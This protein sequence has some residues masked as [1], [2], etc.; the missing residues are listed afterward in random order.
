MM[1]KSANTGKWPAAVF[2][3][4][5]T[6]IWELSVK[7]ELVDA[8]TLPAPS[9]VLKALIA[10]LPSLRGHIWIT[11]QEAG[12]GFL[13]AIGFSIALALLMDFVPLIKKGLYPILVLS[14][15]RCLACGSG[16]A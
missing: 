6:A 4:A 5:L 2:L 3:A 13:A 15:H 11:L 1:K 7:A 14:W 10:E 9:S 16:L 8:F 12:V